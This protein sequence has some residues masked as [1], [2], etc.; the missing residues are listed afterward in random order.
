[1]VPC[2]V[3]WELANIPGQHKGA[4]LVF[5]L[6]MDSA[7]G[8]S[9]AVLSELRQR[10]TQFSCTSPLPLCSSWWPGLS[11]HQEEGDAGPG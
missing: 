8:Y 11:W 9:I 2:N 10:P 3:T 7:W 1:M 6:T 4:E 5:V